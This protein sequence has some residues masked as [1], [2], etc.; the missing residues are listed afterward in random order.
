MQRMK[1]YIVSGDI[2]VKF[3][4]G[5]TKMKRVASA[6]LI[7]CLI[8]LSACSNNEPTEPEVVQE[9]TQEPVATPQAQPDDYEPEE[10]PL[11]TITIEGTLPSGVDFADLERLVNEF[12]RENEQS[13]VGFSVAVF[14]GDYVILDNYY[15]F[16]GGTAPDFEIRNSPDAIFAWGSTTKTLIWVSAMQLYERGLLDLN[17]DIREYLP[18]GIVSLRE[19]SDPVTMLHLMNHT[20]GLSKSPDADHIL[21]NITR[22]LM[23]FDHHIIGQTIWTDATA[24]DFDLGTFL[25]SL[26][27][28]QEWFHA[29]TG[30]IWQLGSI[31]TALA[32]YIVE[33]ISGMPFYEYVNTNIFEPLGMTHT[34]LAPGLSDNQ[35]VREQWEQHRFSRFWIDSATM[36]IHDGVWVESR[37]FD[38]TFSMYPADNAYG[39]ISDLLRYAQALMP[40]EDGNSPLFEN[41]ET[42]AKMLTVSHDPSETNSDG[43]RM[44]HGFVDVSTI[45]PAFADRTTPVIGHGG[46]AL[47]GTS[48]M[49]IDIENNIGLT[50]MT[51]VGAEELF[52]IEIIRLVFGE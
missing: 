21:F 28:S 4:K 15:G 3:T 47:Y 35:V 48:L 16:I 36:T 46:S 18:D 11:R 37:W 52:L 12:Y 25:M 19:D 50:F 34:A 22:N 40:D 39:T 26:E 31:V 20:S 6:F 42:L 8:F 17:A 29:R 9:P 51:N 7:L 10:R 41:S 5:G 24:D 33:N 23:D 38:F 43:P 27:L 14:V 13:M 45:F 30:E 44:H 32:G 2:I 1:F 49:I